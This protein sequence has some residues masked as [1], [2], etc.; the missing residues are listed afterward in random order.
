VQEI[1]PSKEDIQFI[2]RRLHEFNVAQIGYDDTRRIAFFVRDREE[3]ILGGIIGYTYWEW[4]AIDLFWVHEELRG[5]GY[6]SE[7]LAAVESE[8]ISRGCQQALLDT[9][10]FQAPGFYERHGYNLY[11]VL[12]GFAGEYQRLYYR[13]RLQPRFDGESP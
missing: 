1:A 2:G 9:F 13:K 12:E 4:L 5:Q 10:D 11:G 6:G 8:A 3:Q 7:L